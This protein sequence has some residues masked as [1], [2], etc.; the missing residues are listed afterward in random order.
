MHFLI[1]QIVVF[2]LKKTIAF[3]IKPKKKNEKDS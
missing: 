2:A 1:K 3:I